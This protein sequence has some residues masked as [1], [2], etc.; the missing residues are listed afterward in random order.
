MTPLSLSAAAKITGTS[1]STLT[2][3]IK[4]GRLSAE[5]R[6]DGTYRID[7]AELVRAYP[8][9]PATEALEHHA[10]APGTPDLASRT[11]ALEAE[12]AGL[13]ALVEEVR[14]SRDQWQA[15][16]ARL[17][18]AGPERRSWLPWRKAG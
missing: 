4:A 16:A 9:R 5:R 1:K 12:V 18:I 6:P 2:R 15:Q 3:S 10:T 17:A 13:R 8:P 7:P 11:A 14:N